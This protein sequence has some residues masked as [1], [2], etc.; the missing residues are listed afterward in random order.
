[1]EVIA[2]Q[3]ANPNTIPTIGDIIWY[4]VPEMEIK[5]DILEAVA[6]KCNISKDFLP[7]KIVPSDAFKRAVTT[8]SR[9][10]QNQSIDLGNELYEKL[11][12]RGIVANDFKIVKNVI[13]EIRNAAQELIGTKEFQ[14]ADILFATDGG[15]DVDNNWLEKFLAWKTQKGV[16]IQSILLD[17]G[18]CTPRAVT[19]FSNEIFK[20]T[21]LNDTAVTEKIFEGV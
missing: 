5:W 2:V 9:S 13:A 21:Q 6:Q 16:R 14:K 17:V 10:W 8:V 11:M 15:C 12:V 1:M 19:K 18:D 20:V 4:S 3:G 7:G